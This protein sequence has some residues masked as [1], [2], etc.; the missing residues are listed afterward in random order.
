MKFKQN[1]ADRVC[2]YMKKYKL[3]QR[4]IHTR[5]LK[6]KTTP[7]EREKERESGGSVF[8]WC[9]NCVVYH[10][11]VIKSKALKSSFSLF[12]PAFYDDLQSHPVV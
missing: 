6:R 1:K 12:G 5:V 11:K 8:P 7:R 3:I 10:I 9:V 4:N 2:N